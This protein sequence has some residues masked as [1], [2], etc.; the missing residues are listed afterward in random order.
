MPPT[1]LARR[2]PESAETSSLTIR[3]RLLTLLS[4][5]T[6]YGVGALTLWVVEPPGPTAS[7]GLAVLVGLLGAAAAFLLRDA[8]PRLGSWVCLGALLFVLAAASRDLHAVPL[9]ALLLVPAAVAPA[10]LGWRGSALW[11][12]AAIAA[13]A[14][15]SGAIASVRDAV[16]LGCGLAIAW[17]AGTILAQSMEMADLWERQLVTT[18]REMVNALRSRQG[19]LNRTLKALDEAYANLKRNHDELVLARRDA[20]EARTREESFV[21]NVSHELRTPLNLVVGFT[22]VMYLAPETYD[23]AR[24]TPELQGDIEEMYRASRHLQSLVDDILDLSRID[25]SRFP[26]FRQLQD[27]APIIE[28]AAATLAPLFRQRKLAFNIQLPDRLPQLFVDEV[29]IRQVMI[30]LLNNAV[31]F[32]EQGSITVSAHASETD[33]TVSVADTGVGIDQSDLGRIFET[34]RQ[35]GNR[36]LQQGGAG[37]GLALSRQ[38]VQLHGGK[39]DVE[40]TLGQGSVFSF[41]LPLPGALPHSTSLQ[42]TDDRRSVDR[43]SA[44]VL[45]VD[46]DPGLAEMLARYLGD[47]AMVPVGTAQEAD[48]LIER[49][50][51]LAVVVNQLPGGSSDAWLGTI[52]SESARYAVP[53]LRC[54]ISSPSWLHRSNGFDRCLTKPVARDTLRSLIGQP[55]APSTVLVVDDDPAFV[56]LM[57]RM[58]GT[59]PEVAAVLTAY[60]GEQALRIAHQRSPDLAFVDL[61]MPGMGGLQVAAELRASGDCNA[62]RIIGVTATGYAEEALLQRGTYL[63]L[64]QASGLGTTTVVEG[65]RALLKVAHADYL[66]G[67]GSTSSSA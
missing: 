14:L 2:K 28:E 37:L 52:G 32:T 51:P 8:R 54:S 9:M 49:Y 64:S 30:N 56:T 55:P 20:E 67:V 45:V 17:G 57:T 44:P 19:E 10:V 46:P 27:I 60:S 59:L 36:R 5:V 53:V 63:T 41:V 12:I 42:H 66:S 39:M 23:G 40:S 47:R 31:R 1:R 26:M 38:F 29:R 48:A 43:D 15:H 11:V 21:A 13:L 16:V 7:G 4:V 58:L 33:V 24:W 65:L 34:F 50:H 18:Q 35:T 3:S 61:L 22:E 62:M 25:A 6:F